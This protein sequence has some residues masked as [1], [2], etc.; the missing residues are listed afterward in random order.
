MRSKVEVDVDDDVLFTPEA[1][2]KRGKKKRD[3]GND[4]DWRSKGKKPKKNA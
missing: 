4:G 2:P 1:P 3:N